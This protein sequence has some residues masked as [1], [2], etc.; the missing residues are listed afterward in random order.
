M[1]VHARPKDIDLKR[2]FNILNKY[3]QSCP[4]AFFITKTIKAPDQRKNIPN[5][6]NAIKP[7][8]QGL[9]KQKLFEHILVVQLFDN[10]NVVLAD[11][12]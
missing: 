1:F 10:T 12:Y 4:S 11:M 2:F 5:F 7:D 3:T 9:F 8:I 6:H